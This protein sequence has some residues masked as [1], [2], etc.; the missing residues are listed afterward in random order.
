MP[1]KRLARPTSKAYPDTHPHF[2][3]DDQEETFED[4]NE[5]DEQAEWFDAMGWHFDANDDFV[6]RYGN[7]FDFKTQERYYEFVHGKIQKIIHERLMT[8]YKFVRLA[9]PWDPNP[10]VRAKGIRHPDCPHVFVTPDVWYNPKLLVIVQGLGQVAPGQWARKLFTNGHKGQFDYASQLPYIE[11]AKYLGWAIVLCDP[12]RVGDARYR[13][14]HVQRVWEDLVRPAKAN[15]V[16]FVG[17]S[18]GTWATLDLFDSNRIEFK[19][20]V[21]AVVLLDGATGNERYRQDDSVWLFKRTRSI[22][23]IGTGVPRNGE[24]VRTRDHDSVPGMAVGRVFE[25]LEDRLNRFIAR[26]PDDMCNQV[27]GRYMDAKTQQMVQ[28]RPMKK[29]SKQRSKHRL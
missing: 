7:M 27:K 16:M 11:R 26:L 4:E 9:I 6:D 3:R 29:I 17:F 1:N 2:A 12:N 24:E 14:K 19:S 23:Q 22:R 13:S 18:A 25:F 21:K 20:R 28:A 10:S 15:C 5:W 8:E